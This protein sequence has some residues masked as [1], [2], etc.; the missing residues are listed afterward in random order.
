[1]GVSYAS[2]IREW[3]YLRNERSDVLFY[4]RVFSVGGSNG[5]I[6]GDRPIKSKMAEW[7]YLGQGSCCPLQVK[8]LWYRVIRAPIIGL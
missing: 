7:P 8:I 4:G 5:A 6:S 3:P 2:V 1:M